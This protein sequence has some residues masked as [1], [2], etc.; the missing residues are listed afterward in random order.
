MTSAV[1]LL[2]QVLL[3]GFLSF[4]R[5]FSY[6]GVQSLRL[7]IGDVVLL[8]F[9]LWRPDAVIEFLLSGSSAIKEFCWVYLIFLAYGFVLVMRGI[10]LEYPVLSTFQSF[11]FNVYPL[12]FFVGIWIGRRYPGFLSRL[13]PTLAWCTG[14]YGTAYILY[15]NK[16]HVLMPGT[17]NVPIFAQPIGTSVAIL[18]LLCF[19]QRP[20]NFWIPVALNGFV[21]LANQIRSEWLGFLVAIFVWSL[22]SRRLTRFLAAVAVISAV[23]A[24]GF[25]IDLRLPGPRGEISSRNIVARA[26]APFDPELA[27][28]YTPAAKVYGGTATWRKRWW[29]LIWKSVN[30]RTSTMLL[31]HAYGFPLS[32]LAP[33]IRD[34]ALRTPHNVFFYVLGYG[35]WIGVVLFFGF[36]FTILLQLWRA[37]LFTNQCFGIA[38]WAMMLTS[39]LLGNV[40]ET[41]FGAIPVYFLQGIAVA[42]LLYRQFVEHR[43]KLETVGAESVFETG[44]LRHV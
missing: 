23:I 12:Y 22:L 11:V 33:F 24:I 19:P 37:Y 4:G 38:F 30:E 42:P 43:R 21:M 10:A 6:V 3:I 17:T 1:R 34:E 18:G 15:L 7:Y 16:I 20:L 28:E 8:I 29:A 39:G 35:G 5:T 26:V 2:A 13:M 41:P 44:V 25:A 32:F 14:L 27:A 36:Q 31:G 9:L 40:F